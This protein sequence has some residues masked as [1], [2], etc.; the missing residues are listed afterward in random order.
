MDEIRDLREIMREEMLMHKKIL[1]ALQDGPRTVPE[2]ASIL[3]RPA[4]EVMV[5]VMG[6]RKYALVSE[7]GEVTDEDYHKY[8]AAAGEG[9]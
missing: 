4:H 8:G 3:D 7:T 2:I 9:N 5:W 1:A 6:M